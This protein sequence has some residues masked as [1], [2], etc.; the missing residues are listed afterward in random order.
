MRARVELALAALRLIQN[1]PP[2][3]LAQLARTRHVALADTW[4]VYDLAKALTEPTAVWHQLVGCK[5]EIL[6]ELDS[7]NQHGA[8][9]K[10]SPP[11]AATPGLVFQ[12]ESGTWD[13][14]PDVAHSLDTNRTAWRGALTQAPSPETLTPRDPPPPVSAGAALPRLIDTLATVTWVVEGVIHHA[15]ATRL[16]SAAAL[17]KAL[18]A[19]DPTR[20]GDAEEATTWAIDSRLCSH[21]SGSWWGGDRAEQF[22][23]GDV[24]DQLVLLVEW[25]WSAVPSGLSHVLN[26]SPQPSTITDTLTLLATRYPLADSA[27]AAAWHTRGEE[28]GMF[29]SGVPTT[30]LEARM[31]GVFSADLVRTQLPPTHTSVYPDGVDALVSSGPLPQ[32]VSALLRTIALETRGGMAPRFTI[33]TET[34]LR[35]LATSK[36]SALLERLDGVIVGGVPDHLRHAITDL[37]ERASSL[38]VGSRDGVTELVCRDEY[39]TELLTLDHKAA[40]LNLTRAGP[41]TLTTGTPLRVVRDVLGDAGYPTFPNPSPEVTRRVWSDDTATEVDQS[42]WAAKVTEAGTMSHNH[43][44]WEEIIRDAIAERTALSLC[45]A[46][47]DEKRWMVVEPRSLSSGRLRVI[48]TV[49]D[50]ERTLPVSLIVALDIPQA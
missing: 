38:I 3:D 6:D 4:S 22:L 19:L 41:H 13:I 45:V 27:R 44:W 50:V 40:V 11:L 15:P 14:W 49:S 8:A 36:A 48:D 23:D 21:H 1:T 39:L 42:W 20:V 35:T 10:V 28:L 37:A 5:R 18:T 7:L 2:D 32:D 26:E 47:G 25:W 43:V 9:A 16:G 34:I 33:D 24:A 29:I 17:A 30:F 46:V 12:T 31:A